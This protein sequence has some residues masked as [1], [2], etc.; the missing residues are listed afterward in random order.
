MSDSQRNVKRLFYWTQAATLAF[1]VGLM[2]WLLGDSVARSAAYG[3]AAASVVGLALWTFTRVVRVEGGPP[4]IENYDAEIKR[5]TGPPPDL[6]PVA[7][8][9]SVSRRPKVSGWVLL[10]AL[11]LLFVPY[12]PIVLAPIAIAGFAF[13]LWRS[14][15][16]LARLDGHEVELRD[17]DL[18]QLSP[19]GEAIGSIDLRSPFT[20]EYLTKDACIAAYQLRQGSSRVE[21]TSKSENAPWVVRDVLGVEWPPADL[22]VHDF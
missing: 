13:S 22:A 20:Y 7:A 11:A 17:S 14:A 4:A 2:V 3:V 19:E 16:A 8:K 5:Y 18:V 6:S 10:A 12:G 1:L 9:L 15:G 21:F